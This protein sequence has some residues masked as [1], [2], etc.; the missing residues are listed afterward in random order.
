MRYSV[1]DTAEHGDYTGGPKI[2]TE[3]TK[4]EMRKILRAKKAAG[5]KSGD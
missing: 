4:N 1:S 3:E 5:S 2:I